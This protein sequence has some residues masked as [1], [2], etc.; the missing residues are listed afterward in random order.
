MDNLIELIKELNIMQKEQFEI[1]KGEVSYIIKNNIK[2]VN[3]IEHLLDK[4]LDF[5][6]ILGEEIFE[7]YYELTEYLNA[8]DEDAAK[9]YESFLLE[10]FENQKL[11]DENEIDDM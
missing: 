5:A 4:L 3:R 9:D 11:D 2:D 1:S 10:I 7:T 8:L 6:Y